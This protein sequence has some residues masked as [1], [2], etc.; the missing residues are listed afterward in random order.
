MPGQV[1]RQLHARREFRKTL[2]DAEL[3]VERA[4]LMTQYDA[5]GDRRVAC[6]ERHDLA[7]AASASAEV[8]RRIKAASPSS[9]SAVPRCAFQPL[10]SNARK[11]SSGRRPPVCARRRNG[12]RHAQRGGGA[13]G[14]AP[15]ASWLRAPRQQLIGITGRIEPGAQ[16]D[17]RR[18]A[19]VGLQQARTHSVTPQ[20]CLGS[21]YG[22]L[23]K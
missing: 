19:K 16:M 22:Q 20:H 10:A 7:L 11:V 14:A 8:A 15:S 2:V 1:Q 6:A 5:G 12:Q 17:C 21:T 4:V 23:E 3:E 13:G 9:A 18:S